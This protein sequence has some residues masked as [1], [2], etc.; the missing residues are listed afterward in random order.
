MQKY[1]KIFLMV[2]L[3]LGSFCGGYYIFH[4]AFF[5]LSEIRVDYTSTSDYVVSLNERVLDNLDKYKSQSI[6]KI[7]LVEIENE[8]K[9][10]SWIQEVSINRQLPSTL[11]IIIEPKVI[12]ANLVRSPTKIIPVAED[13]QLLPITTHSK[14]PDA[15]LLMGKEFLRN[16][17]L[18]ESALKLLKELPQEGALSADSVSEILPKKN[19]FEIHVKGSTASI[20]MNTE[21][22]PVKAARVSKVIEYLNERDLDGR[23]IDTNFSKKVLVK[24]RNDR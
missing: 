9:S 6:W 7:N 19:E 23:V 21:N 14:A 13:S 24:L 4:A 12:I 22:I 17:S 11:K 8:L 20:L 3:L 10:Q 18:R 5:N 15:P 16:Q 1:F 2:A